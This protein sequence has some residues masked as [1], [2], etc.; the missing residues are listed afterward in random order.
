MDGVM[1]NIEGGEV[2]KYEIL[3]PALTTLLSVVN[4]KKRKKNHKK[5]K[6]SLMN[7]TDI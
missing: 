4:L 2:L 1:A 7:L 6:T 3:N 5:K